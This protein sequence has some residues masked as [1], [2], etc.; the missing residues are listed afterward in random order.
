MFSHPLVREI[1]VV[2]VVKLAFIAA[3]WF[4]FFRGAPEPRLPVTDVVRVSASAPETVIVP[5]T[6]P[7]PTMHITRGNPA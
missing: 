6:K 2:M 1:A 5:P 7:K 4:A 3:L